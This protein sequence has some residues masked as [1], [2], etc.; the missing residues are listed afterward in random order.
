MFY[1]L[2]R[3]SWRSDNWVADRLMGSSNWRKIVSNLC[4]PSLMLWRS[5]EMFVSLLKVAW[6]ATKYQSNGFAYLWSW[7]QGFVGRN[8]LCYPSFDDLSARISGLVVVCYRRGKPTSCVHETCA[9]VNIGFL[10]LDL[11][12]VNI[13]V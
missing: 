4:T 2:L 13:H 3:E 1:S 11:A 7:I 12:N 8:T 5:A 10:L 9:F 6:Q